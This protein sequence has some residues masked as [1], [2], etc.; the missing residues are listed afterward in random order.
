IAQ[1]LRYRVNA[2]VAVA[3]EAPFIATARLVHETLKGIAELLADP[4]PQDL[5]KFVIGHDEAAR[6]G[7]LAVDMRVR[8]DDHG[9]VTNDRRRDGSIEN[10]HDDSSY[11]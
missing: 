3:G 2:L 6:F 11:H 5:F 9:A 1:H 7:L 10:T 4:I 8:A